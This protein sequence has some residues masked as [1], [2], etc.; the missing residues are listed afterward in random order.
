MLMT[1]NAPFLSLM[2]V[3]LAAIKTYQH[4]NHH[5][6]SVN[7]PSTDTDNG[8]KRKHFY[9]EARLPLHLNSLATLK[10]K[11]GRQFSGIQ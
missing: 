10:T 11:K 1:F 3:K 2:Y 5:L 7:S 9:R 4:T 8:C 6:L